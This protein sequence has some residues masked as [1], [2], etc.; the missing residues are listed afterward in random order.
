M[1]SGGV[2]VLAFEVGQI[3][4]EQMTGRLHARQT[5]E[6]VI[7]IILDDV[8]ALHGAEFGDVQLPSGSELL[9]VAQRGL[10]SPFLETFRRVSKD[11]GCAC[12]RALRSGEPVIIR[13][14]LCD[15]DYAPFREAALAAGY[16][17]VQ[18]TPLLTSNGQLLGVISTL[19]A[20]P[21]EPTMIEMR[22]LKA[23][24]LIAS[25]YLQKLLGDEVLDDKANQMSAKL[26]ADRISSGRAALG[27]E[28]SI[29]D[30]G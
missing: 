16:R 22:A 13:D 9:I 23:Y 15:E 30:S 20:A 5:F 3:M 14:V 2:R 24:C 17:G 7:D 27:D 1:V 11:D 21:H 12:G 28:T 26:Y 4:L 8:I 10:L 18:S 19:F 6:S 29:P 25:S